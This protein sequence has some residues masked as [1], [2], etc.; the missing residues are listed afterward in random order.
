[1][2]WRRVMARVLV[3]DDLADARLFLRVTLRSAGHEVEEAEDG[4]LALERL[5]QGGI[6]LVISDGLMPVMDGFRLCL[7][8]RR[9]ESLSAT[10]FILYTA[11]FTQPDDE[12]LA[13]SMGADAYLRKPAEIRVILDTVARVLAQ[14][15][16]R[17]LPDL[18]A[19]PTL[20]AVFEQYGARIESALDTKVAELADARSDRDTFHAMLDYL[21]LLISTYDPEG[22]VDF[23]NRAATEFAGANLT[24]ET[25]VTLLDRFASEDRVR[26]DE[27]VR[28]VLS[29]GQPREIT[30]RATRSDGVARRL[31]LTILPYSDVHGAALGAVVAGID[32]T[33]QE[34]HEELLLYLA[35]HDVLTGLPNRRVLNERFDAVLAEIGQGTTFSLLFVDIDRFKSVNDEFGHDV[36]DSVIASV[37]RVIL[38]TA[39]PDDLVVRLCGDEFV[40]LAENVDAPAAEELAERIRTAVSSS[41][42]V[43][44]VPDRRVTVSIGIHV[45]PEQTSPA[46]SLKAADEKMYR[47]KR[48]AAGR[49]AERRA[50]APVGLDIRLESLSPDIT[51]TPVF[52]LEGG[53]LVRCI[54]QPAFEAAGRILSQQEVMG[55][56]SLQGAGP[57]ITQ[58]VAKRVLESVPRAG[59]PCSMR[60]G[61]GDVLDPSVFERIERVAAESGA[62]PTLLLFAVPA[63]HL[64]AGGLV[65]TWLQ[66]ARRSPIKLVLD[67]SD[68]DLVGLAETDFDPFAEVQVSGTRIPGD[69]SETQRL[70]VSVLARIRDAGAVATATGL[71]TELLLHAA[72]GNGF[73]QGQGLALA[74]SV[75]RIEELPETAGD[76]RHRTLSE[77]PLSGT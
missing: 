43:P 18:N 70:L 9:D 74:P 21:P 22:N 54:A 40:V 52:A 31:R 37:G 75:R 42:A 15:P 33:E 16:T 27:A 10:P 48:R 44:A 73:E 41:C 63:G 67:C 13:N 62:D 19:E 29:D 68:T 47:A 5:R 77:L 6:D 1:M 50:D 65:K 56:P 23:S 3:V 17:G 39:G 45:L 25:S 14:P 53:R 12:L 55:A 4:S 69:E 36:G 46:E 38:E 58:L 72:I 26:L 2:D 32:V 57:A 49:A 34:E 71:D 24:A 11:S 64:L 59:L 28:A 7:E 35:E 66:A 61:I 51:F 60:L 20:L 30:E 8:I 76:D